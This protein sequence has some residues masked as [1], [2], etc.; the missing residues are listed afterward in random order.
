MLPTRVTMRDPRLLDH[1]QCV[2]FCIHDSS[3]HFARETR[4][5]AP[6]HVKL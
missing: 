6:N 5:T 1:L 4:G 3:A 2:L